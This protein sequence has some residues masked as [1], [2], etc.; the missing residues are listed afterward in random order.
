MNGNELR[1]IPGA[2]QYLKES[3]EILDVSH[4]SLESLPNEIC[5]LRFLKSLVVHHNNLS[6]LPR[7]FGQLRKLRRLD[8]SSNHLNSLPPSLGL[9]DLENFE[10]QNNPLDIP[11]AL[12][13]KGTG[14]MNF[15][16]FSGAHGTPEGHVE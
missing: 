9:I 10:F 7:G 13:E 11:P 2:I 12:L 5:R 4:N 14:R 16:T 3:I 15:L 6:A 8:L 1:Q